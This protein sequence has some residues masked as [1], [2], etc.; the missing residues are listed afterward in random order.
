[1]VYCSTTASSPYQL[2]IIVFRGM[3]QWDVYFRPD[4]LVAAEDY[5]G[6]I[7]VGEEDGRGG[8]GMAEEVVFGAEV[9]EGVCGGGAVDV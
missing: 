8:G 7:G 2:Y 5:G 9:E 3:E 6:G 4:V 1:M